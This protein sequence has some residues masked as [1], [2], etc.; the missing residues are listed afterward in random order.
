[1]HADHPSEGI[2]PSERL[3]ISCT[4]TEN[5]VGRRVGSG[6]RGRS[7]ATAEGIPERMEISYTIAV[8]KVRVTHRGFGVRYHNCKTV[9]Q[10][11]D[12]AREVACA[13]KLICTPGISKGRKF[14][15]RPARREPGG[16][17]KVGPP[18][19]PKLRLWISRA[20]ESAKD[21]SGLRSWI[22]GPEHSGKGS[23]EADHLLGVLPFLLD[24]LPKSLPGA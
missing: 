20:F 9:L 8:S 5:R 13:I 3:A 11:V 14:V 2:E 16:V 12:Q 1:M 18:V 7:S 17:R 4:P 22:V 19:G 10:V 6:S 15:Q 21:C 23:L 24:V